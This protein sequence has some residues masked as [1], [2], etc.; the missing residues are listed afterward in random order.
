[1]D[2]G[3]NARWNRNP[4][5]LHAQ[6]LQAIDE[7]RLIPALAVV[8][9]RDPHGERRPSPHLALHPENQGLVIGDY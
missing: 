6:S 2:P 7:S 3:P 4:R 9:C 5:A 1:M 8:V